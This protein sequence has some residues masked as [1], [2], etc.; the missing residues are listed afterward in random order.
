MVTGTFPYHSDNIKRLAHM[1]QTKPP[2][3]NPEKISPE[4]LD[5]LQKILVHNP[6]KRLTV[7]QTRNHQW[8]DHTQYKKMLST[9]I[10]DYL[11]FKDI[12]SETVTKMKLNDN[13]CAIFKKSLSEKSLE[14]QTIISLI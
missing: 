11:M 7:S 13:E 10:H 1:I 4:L 8:F 5:L 12:D 9:V 3:L 14:R 2:D 6:S